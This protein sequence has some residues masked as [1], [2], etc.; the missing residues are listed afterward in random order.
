M[1]I[2]GEDRKGKQGG[3]AKRAGWPVMHG[4]NFQWTARESW[5]SATIQMLQGE[6]QVKERKVSQ[7]WRHPIHIP[8]RLFALGDQST[9]DDT[10][11]SVVYIFLCLCWRLG[12]PCLKGESEVTCVHEYEWLKCDRFFMWLPMCS[13]VMSCQVGGFCRLDLF[14]PPPSPFLVCVHRKAPWWCYLWYVWPAIEGKD[15]SSTTSGPYPRESDAADGVAENVRQNGRVRVGRGEEGVEARTVP[16]GDLWPRKKFKTP[17]Q[18]VSQA[19][20]LILT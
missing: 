5:L 8:S 15:K 6:S 10:E 11:D 13:H 1:H 19:H 9:R 14:P 3:K 20:Q 16:V 12:T 17:P 2:T 7:L 4:G 18:S